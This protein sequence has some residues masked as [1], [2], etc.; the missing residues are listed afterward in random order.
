MLRR[1]NIKVV[2]KQTVCASLSDTH[3]HSVAADNAA[4]I[5][6]PVTPINKIKQ[7]IHTA[8]I[9]SCYASADLILCITLLHFSQFTPQSVILINY[10]HKSL[11]AKQTPTPLFS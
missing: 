3:T 9:D 5:N 1:K 7:S 11:A 10:T 4:A 8:Q 2:L 6:L